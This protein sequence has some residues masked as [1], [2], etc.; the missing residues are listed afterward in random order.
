MEQLPCE[1]EAKLPPRRFLCPKRQCRFW[2]Y[3][4]RLNLFYLLFFLFFEI[5]L[6]EVQ[7]KSHWSLNKNM[8]KF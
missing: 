4:G 1:L 6:E 7:E 5:S 3:Q 8:W 2:R